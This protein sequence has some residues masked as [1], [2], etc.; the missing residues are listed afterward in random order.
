M[1]TNRRSFL[2]GLLGIAVAPVVAKAAEVATEFPALDDHARH[3][4]AHAEVIKRH[5]DAHRSLNDLFKAVYADGSSEYRFG[6]LT[7]KGRS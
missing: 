2:R 6:E 4:A 5:I 1:S 7:L 3:V